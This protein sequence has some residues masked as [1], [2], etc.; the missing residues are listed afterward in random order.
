MKNFAEDEQKVYSITLSNG[1]EQ[2]ILDWS[3]V[4]ANEKSAIIGAPRN[5]NM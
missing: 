5:V 4:C 2:G 1:W 3:N